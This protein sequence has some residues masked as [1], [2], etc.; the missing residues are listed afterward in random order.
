VLLGSGLCARKAAQSLMFPSLALL[1]KLR[2]PLRTG[3]SGRR[4]WRQVPKAQRKK[5]SQ[6]KSASGTPNLPFWP[7]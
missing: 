7:P 6:P 5:R 4:I 1:H 3:R 2:R